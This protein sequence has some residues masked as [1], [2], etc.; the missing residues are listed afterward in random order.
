MCNR[1]YRRYY[2]LWLIKDYLMVFTRIVRVVGERERKESVLGKPVLKR[3]LQ[4]QHNS[5]WNIQYTV[6]AHQWAPSLTF[7]ILYIGEGF[8]QTGSHLARR[9]KPDKSIFEFSTFVPSKAI[10]KLKWDW[11]EIVWLL[12]AETCFNSSESPSSSI[13]TSSLRFGIVAAPPAILFIWN[14]KKGDLRLC[15]QNIGTLFHW[16][17]N[18]VTL[19]IKSFTWGLSL[20]QVHWLLWD[21]TSQF[22]FRWVEKGQFW[23]ES[24]YL[25]SSWICVHRVHSY[26]HSVYKLFHKFCKLHKFGRNNNSAILYSIF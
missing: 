6:D 16:I 24:I 4:H 17:N 14:V 10:P 12:W 13:E 3:V 25:I 21:W 7:L 18:F 5:S 1:F 11:G 15:S 19:A 23:L 26:P 2:T 22:Q 20:T 8:G 9:L